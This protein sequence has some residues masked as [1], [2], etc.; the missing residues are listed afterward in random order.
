MDQADILPREFLC[1]MVDNALTYRPQQMRS[2]P[3]EDIERYTEFKGVDFDDNMNNWNE[4]A[5]YR[6]N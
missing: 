3:H 1:E 5:C 2:M 6:A 4:L